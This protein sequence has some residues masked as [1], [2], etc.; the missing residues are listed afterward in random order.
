MFYFGIS[1]IHIKKRG[2]NVCSCLF[3]D[4]I[5]RETYR[6]E[7]DR[8]P[9]HLQRISSWE[10]LQSCTSDTHTLFINLHE[11]SGWLQS[12]KE[13]ERYYLSSHSFYPSQI[14]GVSQLLQKCGFSVYLSA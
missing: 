12:K 7:H 14:N 2:K 3:C 9:N 6:K 10:E 4:M 5:E 11:Q 1:S 13:E 8:M